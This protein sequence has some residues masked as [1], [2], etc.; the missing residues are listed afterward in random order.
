MHDFCPISYVTFT[1]CIRA[2]VEMTFLS[3]GLIDRGSGGQRGLA[4]STPTVPPLEYLYGAIF[5]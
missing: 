1:G 4:P 5:V 3:L 2:F